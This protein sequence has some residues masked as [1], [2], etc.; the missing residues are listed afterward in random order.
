ML[1]AAGVSVAALTTSVLLGLFRP[2][3]G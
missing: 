1:A 3:V 2:I